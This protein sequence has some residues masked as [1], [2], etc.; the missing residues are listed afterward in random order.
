MVRPGDRGSRRRD[1]RRP[2][3]LRGLRHGR[4]APRPGGRIAYRL[5]YVSRGRGKRRVMEPMEF[6][7]RLS[8]IIASPRYPLIRYGWVL[9]P[10]SR[11][12]REVVP[13]PRERR[14]DACPVHDRSSPTMTRTIRSDPCR[15]STR[16]S[17]ATAPS[18][19]GTTC[20]KEMAASVPIRRSLTPLIPRARSILAAPRH[21]R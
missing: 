20:S 15:Q 4:G 6:M 10:H 1:L 8:A 11:W 18:Q 19:R 9:A 12:R 2:G 5:K 7:A 17:T 21:I 13:C 16:S 14:R 3:R